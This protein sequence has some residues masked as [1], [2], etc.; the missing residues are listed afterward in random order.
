[1]LDLLRRTFPTLAEWDA[2]K[3]IVLPGIAFLV[4][5]FIYVFAAM[6]LLVN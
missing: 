5:A 1:M 3:W 6:V 2:G 4:G